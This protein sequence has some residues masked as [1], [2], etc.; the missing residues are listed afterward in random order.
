[1]PPGG[2]DTDYSNPQQVLDPN[3][4]PQ[5]TSSAPDANT[6]FPNQAPKADEVSQPSLDM[7]SKTPASPMAFTYESEARLDANGN[8]IIYHPPSNDGGGAEEIAGFTSNDNPDQLAQI[9][10]TPPNQRMGLIIRLME[11][12]TSPVKNWSTNPAIQGLLQDTAFHRGVGGA[13][14]ILQAATGQ[15]LTKSAVPTTQTLAALSSMN[16]ADAINAITQARKNYE[17]TVIGTRPNLDKGLQNRI[18]QAGQ[19]F[20]KQLTGEKS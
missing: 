3:T 17:S 10:A 9:K 5:L 8:P 13:G 14:A 6:P 2:G 16:P 4:P 1:L 15:P 12:Y 18:N 7:G 19:Y 11:D 20:T